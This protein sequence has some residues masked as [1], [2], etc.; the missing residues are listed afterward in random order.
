MNGLPPIPMFLQYSANEAQYAAANAAASPSEQAALAHFQ[1]NAGKL[2]SPAALLGDYTSLQVVLGAFGMSSVASQTAVLRALMTQNPSD[3]SSLAR[4]LG[5]PSYL[6]FAQLMSTW[7]PPPFASASAVATVAANYERNQFEQQAGQQIPGMTQALYFERTIGGVTSVNGL[8]SDR[9]LLP[10]V[11]NAVGL[12]S[13]AVQSLDY[14]QQVAIVTK[15]VDFK[16]FTNPSWVKSASEQYLVQQQMLSA[17]DSGPAP[18]SL[19]AAFGDGSADDATASLLG[20][21]PGAGGSA[22]GGAGGLVSLFA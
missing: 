20:L 3:P 5:N 12:P 9:Q 10:V 4:Q 7:S 13:D 16:Q 18:G 17:G 1:A 2:T 15:A 14:N 8:L 21:L 19:L 22:G 11:L 6:R